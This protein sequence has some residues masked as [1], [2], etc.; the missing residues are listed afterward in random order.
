MRRSILRSLL[1]GA[2]LLTLTMAFAP[3]QRVNAQTAEEKSAASQESGGEQED[4]DFKWHLI[5]TGI[6]ALG[7]GWAIWKFA[8]GF[9][10]ARSA[11]IQKAI[12]EA[13]G[14][15]LQ[16]DLRYSEIDRK[17]ALLP[18]EVNKL[19]EEARIAMDREYTRRKEDT[20]R[21]LRHIQ[22]TSAAEIEAIRLESIRQLRQ[23]TAQ[24][25]LQRAER[26]LAE[27]SPDSSND[28]LMQDFLHLVER[29]K[30]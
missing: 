1:C 14:L 16:A 8:P 26:R 21:D 18:E 9:F 20:A 29:G 2:F 3:A 27:R 24:L 30:N 22:D 7:L 12:Q 19:K 11:D 13:T 6:F 10:N 28:E 23:R 25:A 4:A 17:M 15:K 5:N